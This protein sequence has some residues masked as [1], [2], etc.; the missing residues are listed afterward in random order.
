M[1]Y[2]NRVFSDLREELDLLFPESLSAEIVIHMQSAHERLKAYRERPESE[3]FE[4]GI[5][6]DANRLSAEILRTALVSLDIQQ[7]SIIHNGP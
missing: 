2:P 4:D 1:M 5:A 3:A 6:A 7:P